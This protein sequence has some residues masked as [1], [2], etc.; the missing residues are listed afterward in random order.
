MIKIK[1]EQGSEAW[2][3]AKL[4]LFSGTRFATLMSGK[5]TKGYKDL[6]LNVAGEMISRTKDE[7]YTNQIMERGIELES[8]ARYVYQHFFDCKVEEVGLCLHDDYEDWAGISPDGLIGEDGGLEIKC[9]LMKTHMNYI[10]ANTLPNDYKWQV[11]GSL[12]VT[13]RKYWDFMSYYPGM[14][15]FVFRVKPDE[16]MNSEL[17]TR[18]KEAIEEVKAEIDLYNKYNVFN[19]IEEN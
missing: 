19:E 15:P 16:E 2:F 13:G 3:E 9:P 1:I 11:Q 10:K 5:S 14:T 17:E 8:D 6:I 7:T 12:F 18:L 4:G